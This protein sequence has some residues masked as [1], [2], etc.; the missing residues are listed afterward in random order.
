MKLI[1]KYAVSIIIVIIFLCSYNIK[2]VKDYWKSIIQSDGKGYYA[3][4]PATIIYQ[5]LNFNFFDSIEKKYPDPQLY[6]DY[7]VKYKDIN[8]NK[9]PAG[10]SIAMLPFFLTAHVS[11]TVLGY[12]ADGYS[13]LYLILIHISTIFY[14]GVGLFFLKKI[15]E[16][17]N[18][19]KTAIVFL[20][21]AIVFGTN[22]FY[23]TV[24]DPAM[25]HVYSFSFC[26]LFIYLITKY[27]SSP[28]PRL[29]LITS[30]ILGI[31]MLIRPVNGI[32][33]LS[34]PFFTGNKEKLFAGLKFLKLKK[35]YT[36]FSVLLLAGIIFIQLIIYKIQTGSFFVDSYP[37]ESFNWADFNFIN[38]LISYKKGLF[39]YT[40]L[41]FFIVIGLYYLF[42]TNK[43]L[44][45]TSFL[46]FVVLVYVL[47]SWWSWWYGGSFGSRVMID[48]YA[49]IAVLLLLGYNYL[50]KQ[51][52]K[53]I[54]LS[55]MVVFI[56]ICQIQIYQY[57][58]Y[59]IHWEKMD[60][61]HYWN[62]FLRVDLII[63]NQNPNKDLL[64]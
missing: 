31:I 16:G 27:F 59:F 46:F 1:Y 64:N 47:S 45:F 50:N 29:L 41:A 57:R 48:Y 28:S 52:L 51:I 26:T 5:D 17:Y 44:F 11:S 37:G 34:I 63:K 2:W 30:F 42:K 22:L 10:T 43:Y 7:R 24:C 62:V 6:Y 8:L 40:P 15:L 12:P 53:R 38:F 4:L 3:Y 60:K 25:S 32:I 33:L 54:Y 14:L 23:Y 36:I 35:M 9:Y 39:I 58:Y 13:K 19:S 49:F 20:L 56:I 61:E 55:M 18:S 21:F